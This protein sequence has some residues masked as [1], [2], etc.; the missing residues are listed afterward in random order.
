M[1]GSGVLMF[2]GAFVFIR[3]T[4]LTI[5]SHAILICDGVGFGVFVQAVIFGMRPNL[6]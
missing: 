4:E 2:C 3:S 6:K 1:V 5:V